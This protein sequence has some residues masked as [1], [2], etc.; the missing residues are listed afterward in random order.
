[1]LFSHRGGGQERDVEGK[2]FDN[3]E[4]VFWVQG[5]ALPFFWTSGEQETI[6]SRGW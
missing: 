4:R 6:H 3:A 1:M 2:S 5:P